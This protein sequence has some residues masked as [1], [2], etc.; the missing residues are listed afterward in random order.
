MVLSYQLYK[1]RSLDPKFNYKKG[2][3]LLS[4]LDIVG[5]LLDEEELTKKEQRIKKEELL[6]LYEQI[7]QESVIWCDNVEESSFDY[8]N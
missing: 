1:E 8:E 2:P 3:L 6:P 4:F 5:I 7:K